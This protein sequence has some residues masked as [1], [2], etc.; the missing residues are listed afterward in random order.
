[1]AKYPGLQEYVGTSGC[2]RLTYIDEEPTIDVYLRSVAAFEQSQTGQLIL[3]DPT[4]RS[5]PDISFI[6]DEQVDYWSVISL[7]VDSFGLA[8]VNEFLSELL[9][10]PGDLTQVDELLPKLQGLLNQSHALWGQLSQDLEGEHDT[11]QLSNVWMEYHPG[12]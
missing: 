1:M 5:Y 11:R 4:E 9:R 6:I 8:G 2:Y 12:I 3:P 10:Q 7:Q